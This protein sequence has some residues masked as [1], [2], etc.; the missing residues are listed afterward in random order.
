MGLSEEGKNLI[1]FIVNI[2]NFNL[3][4]FFF[5]LGDSNVVMCL[6][7]FFFEIV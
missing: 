5:C 6:F 4:I 1:I 7:F 3:F 2:N